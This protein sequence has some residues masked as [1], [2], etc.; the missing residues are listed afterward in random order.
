MINGMAL[1][2]ARDG[3]P[4][5]QQPAGHTCRPTLFLHSYIFFPGLLLLILCSIHLVGDPRV[6][7]RQAGK[8]AI[9]RTVFSGRLMQ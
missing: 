2:F 9:L 6:I 7:W 3:E 4:E 8:Y 1:L 5:A